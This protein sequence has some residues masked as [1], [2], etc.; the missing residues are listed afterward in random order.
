MLKKASANLLKTGSLFALTLAFIPGCNIGKKDKV[1]SASS[2]TEGSTVLCK[3]DGK[4]A[5]NEAEFNSNITQ[6]L[7]ANPY[8]KGAGAQ[9]LPLSIK[10]KFFDELIKQELIIVDATKQNLEADGE[11]KKALEDMQKLIKRSL[12]V[13][14]FEKKIY[15]GIVIEEAEIAK[16]FEEN[17][18]RYMKN[19]GGVL[20]GA[21]RFDSEREAD[22]FQSKNS[23]VST[24]T[25]FEK[26]AKDK[27]GQFRSFGR[28]SK[29]EAPRGY[30]SENV[31]QQIKDAAL[32]A[33]SLPYLSKVK[34]GKDIWV[35]HASDKH[36]AEIFE[37]NEIKPQ[38]IN[39]L[40]N[41]KFREKLDQAIAN[42]KAKISVEVNE[43]FFKEKA[44]EGDHAGHDHETK[45]EN[46]AVGA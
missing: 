1:I 8:F 30:Q 46:P 5:I 15:D 22:L 12:T 24:Y 26:A 25:D 7:Q 45:Q 31:P 38:I 10:R 39:M 18:E 11:F 6:M 27:S 16:H 33:K 21:V 2:S 41:N 3:I 4:A 9:N 34:V 28:V 13:Q 32:N 42:L 36:D 40:K 35:V 17:K 44:P 14:F 37:L 43:E 23:S 20:V 29:Q 19:A